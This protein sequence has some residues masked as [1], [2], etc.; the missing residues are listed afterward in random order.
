LNSLPTSAQAGYLFFFGIVHTAKLP[1]I[2]I[3]CITGACACPLQLA[4]TLC[5]SPKT[6]YN[7]SEIGVYLQTETINI[8]LFQWFFI[9]VFGAYKRFNI[10]TDID[11]PY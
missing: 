4:A 5:H 3:G 2:P 6:A 1:T 11:Y 7:R 9:S 8:G 10:S